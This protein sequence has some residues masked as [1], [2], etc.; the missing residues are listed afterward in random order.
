M[1][2]G[3]FIIFIPNVSQNIGMQYTTASTSSIIQASAPIFTIILAFIFLKESKKMSKIFGSIIAMTGVILLVSGG[4]LEFGGTT[5]GNVLILVSAVSYA[6]S[7]IILKKGLMEIKPSHLLSFETFFGFIFLVGAT[8]LFGDFQQILSF[9]LYTW[10]LI[11]ILAVFASAIAAILYYVV[12]A[13][14]ELSKLIVFLYLIPLFAVVFSYFM[15]GEVISIQVLLF[16]VLII[17]GV[18]L[19]QKE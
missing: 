12:L 17:F 10:F 14:T 13:D 1:L 15:L 11:G 5:Y 7:G 18:A 16:A 6:I 19:A 8:V 9:D 3:L 4:R 2:L